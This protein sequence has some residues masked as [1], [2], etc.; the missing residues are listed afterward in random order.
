MN[1]NNLSI[2]FY[3]S[4]NKEQSNN[5]LNFPFYSSS[6][7]SAA[8]T[9]T[10]VPAG[11]FDTYDPFNNNCIKNNYV[12]TN[13]NNGDFGTYIKLK[14]RNLWL[15]DTK[16]HHLYFTTNDI[17]LGTLRR[18]EQVSRQPA[19]FYVLYSGPYSPNQSQS[20]RITPTFVLYKHVGFGNQELLYLVYKEINGQPYA[21]WTQDPF[22]ATIFKYN[23]IKSSDYITQN[24]PAKYASTGRL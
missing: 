16:D 12:K 19:L 17:P 3:K 6:F 18:P 13:F 21:K 2:A 5:T 9:P 11:P 1:I 7:G 22:A 10:K 4:I 24:L 14:N 20:V 8:Q 23:P 15:Y